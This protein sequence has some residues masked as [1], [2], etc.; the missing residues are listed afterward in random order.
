MH[1][2]G[3]PFNANTIFLVVATVVVLGGL[4]WFFFGSSAAQPPLSATKSQNQA[5]A[6]FDALVGE[7]GPITFDL[8]ILKDPRFLGLVDLSTPIQPEQQGR[9]DP[10]SPIPG[11]A[12][13][14]NSN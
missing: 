3:S 4:Y 2:K 12:S 14:T 5:Q 8:T 10:F 1:F 11:A 7:L 13:R 9:R 6:Q